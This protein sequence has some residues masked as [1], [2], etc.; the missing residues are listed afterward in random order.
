MYQRQLYARR[1]TSSILFIYMINRAITIS[2]NIDGHIDYYFNDVFNITK[3]ENVLAK[4]PCIYS[5][6]F[7]FVILTLLF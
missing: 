5:R 1:R 3:F 4:Q 2:F 6:S 7:L